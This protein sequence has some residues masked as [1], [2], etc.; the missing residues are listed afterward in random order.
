MVARLA[1]ERMPTSGR[2]RGYPGARADIDA[3]LQ[4]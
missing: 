2:A 1:L 4:R 3:A